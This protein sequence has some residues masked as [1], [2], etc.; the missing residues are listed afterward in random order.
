MYSYNLNGLNGVLSSA[1]TNYFIGTGGP[2]QRYFET[3]GERVDIGPFP[4]WHVRHLFTQA[5]VDETNVRVTGLVGGHLSINIRTKATDA[6]SPAGT[7][8]C[9]NNG[10]NGSGSTY[11]GMAAPQPLVQWNSDSLSTVGFT[12][13]SPSAISTTGWNTVD[14]SHLPNFAE[15]PYLITGEP[16]FME[17][18]QELANYAPITFGNQNYP[19]VGVINTSEY[20][21]DPASGKHVSVNGNSRWGIVL[22]DG[23]NRI[24]AWA[25]RNMVSALLLPTTAYDGSNTPQYFA[26][27]VADNAGFTADVIALSPTSYASTNGLWWC[28]GPSSV[29]FVDPWQQS[30]GIFEFAKG[31]LIAKNHSLL[32]SGSAASELATAGEGVM[33][34]WSH[35]IN[36]FGVWNAFA[37]QQ[38]MYQGERPTSALAVS[39]TLVF[40]GNTDIAWTSG[41]ANFV[42]NSA[43]NAGGSGGNMII[44]QG[45]KLEFVGPALVA[46]VHPNYPTPAQY[47]KY[48]AW[49]VQNVPVNVGTDL[50]QVQLVPN[51]DLSGT[52]VVNTDSSTITNGIYVY[53]TPVN[54]PSTGTATAFSGTGYLQNFFASSS[55][56]QAVGFT[57]DPTA[58]GTL[59]TRQAAIP[60]GTAS[61]GLAFDPKF[62]MIN[63]LLEAA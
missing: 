33:Q 6:A 24:A 62:A 56:A 36:T 15:Y 40:P 5:Q 48:K 46:S 58:Y 60:T 20:Q 13:P 4:S 55:Y 12:G 52:P 37:E 23:Y 38:G 10:H 25:F 17:L 1:P 8:I 7:I 11:T 45:D 50:W 29:N 32:S 9:N 49:Y 63:S 41:S 42:I 14:F 57:M 28:N 16:Q 22:G 30:Y 2:V 39:D 44:S 19:A 21:P 43:A 18:V 34:W 61:G 59:A 26:D 3:S 35:T 53:Y 47:A 54:S 51:A 31:Y 27:M